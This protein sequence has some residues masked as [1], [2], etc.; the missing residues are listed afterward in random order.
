[1]V[2]VFCAVN[3]VVAGRSLSTWRRS[4]SRHS[5]TVVDVFCAVNVVVAGRSLLTWRRSL[6]RHS[7]T[8]LS[9]LYQCQCRS[10]RLPST[11]RSCL[12]LQSSTSRCSWSDVPALEMNVSLGLVCLSVHMSQKT[13]FQTSQ[14]FL[15]TYPCLG[16][17]PV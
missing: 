17:V 3:V 13:Y 14:N 15:Y 12:S 1:V 10:P 6:S 2:D 16:N 4:L 8:R 11:T 5:S 7:S 9:T